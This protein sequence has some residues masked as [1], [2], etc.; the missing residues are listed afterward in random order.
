MVVAKTVEDQ[1]A[2]QKQREARKKAKA[3]KAH[4]MATKAKSTVLAY[5]D[6]GRAISPPGVVV[7]AVAASSLS[8]LLS[9]KPLVV[10][11][12]DDS[13]DGSPADCTEAEEGE[14]NS[15]VFSNIA[16]DKSEGR[17]GEG[18]ELDDAGSDDS[19]CADDEDEEGL[20]G[21]GAAAMEGKKSTKA[22][23]LS[24]RRADATND[25]LSVFSAVEVDDAG[26]KFHM[27]LVCSWVL[28]LNLS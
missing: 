20:G 2:W 6:F 28:I 17:S 15:S 5:K 24:K 22:S 8:T 16:D 4:V 1:K 18:S 12:D 19:D 9:N 23:T 7:N 26:T 10:L 14:D 13:D 27:C 21:G 11:L 25:L 3:D